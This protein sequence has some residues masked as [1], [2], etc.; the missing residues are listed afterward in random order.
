MEFDLKTLCL[1]VLRN[2]GRW[3]TITE[4]IP[5]LDLDVR[6][7]KGEWLAGNV[8]NALQSLHQEGRIES[9]VGRHPYDP[10]ES[11]LVW[12]VMYGRR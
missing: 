2:E 1:L 6:Q 10:L 11:C 7:L 8:Y 9:Q 3:M 12:R 5:L 4:M